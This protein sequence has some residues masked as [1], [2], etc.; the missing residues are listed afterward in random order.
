LYYQ[1]I[2]MNYNNIL[3][4]HLTRFN[5]VEEIEKVLVDNN[6][7]TLCAEKLFEH[8]EKGYLKVFID[9][10]TQCVIA[11]TH[12][13]DKKKIQFQEEFTNFLKNMK[14]INFSREVEDLSIDIILDK[15]SSKGIDS[16]TKREKLFLENNSK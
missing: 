6:I 12:K 4:I 11:Y 7:K 16:L 2:I 15:I 8:K 1:T 13:D 14:S 10:Q 5:T 9:G 3:S